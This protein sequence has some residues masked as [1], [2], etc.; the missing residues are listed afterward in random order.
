MSF[1]PTTSS[2]F[3]ALETRRSI[4]TITNESPIPQP[5]IVSIVESAI[6]HTPSAFNVQAARAVILFGTEHEK[7]WD[8]ADG[9]LKKKV[10][11][12]VYQA[13]GPKVAGLKAGY[14]TVLWLEDQDDLD[15]LGKK[16]ASI[17][18]LVPECM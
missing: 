15:L 5:P 4:Y 10:P 6:K 13:L 18:H 2:L 9:L 12:N 16:N 7:L 11:E 3:T 8:I 17:Q 1:Q 14:G